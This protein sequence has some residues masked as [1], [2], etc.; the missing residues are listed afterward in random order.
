MAEFDFTPPAG[1]EVP[2]PP[3]TG[4]EPL[5]QDERVKLKLEWAT[6]M[7]ILKE[8]GVS[9]EVQKAMEEWR[10]AADANKDKIE[11]KQTIA[12]LKDVAIKQLTSIGIADE[13]IKGLVIEIEKLVQSVSD[14]WGK[15]LKL[16]ELVA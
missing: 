3:G 8:K 1:V 9:P 11:V 12:E 4:I 10:A 16:E 15:V 7:Q 13:K 14:G 2:L 6:E 5:T